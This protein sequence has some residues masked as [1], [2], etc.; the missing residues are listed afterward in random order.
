MRESPAGQDALLLDFAD[1]EMAW[2]RAVQAGRALRAAVEDGRLPDVLDVVPTAQ[3]VLVQ[4]RPGRGID[5]LGVRRVLRSAASAAD[6]SDRA[7]VDP[8]GADTLTIPVDYDGEDLGAVADRLGTDVDTVAAAHAAIVWRVQFVGF[9][10][11]FGY[12]VPHETPTAELARS[13]CA[14]PRRAESRPS[15][16]AGAVAVA[17]GY[18]AVYPRSS[19]GGWNLLGHTDIALWDVDRDP[20]GL[21]EPGRPV[22]FEAT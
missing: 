21:L 15:V 13:L 19:P 9:A 11:G 14:I 4:A 20:P 6:D 3:A 18:S 8:T 12:L 16:P 7:G 1:D 17:A 2:R 22:R 5:R 10:P